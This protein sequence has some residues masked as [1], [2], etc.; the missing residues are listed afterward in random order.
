MNIDS[1]RWNL[2]VNHIAAAHW[3]GTDRRRRLLRRAGLRLAPDA[4]VQYGT[5]FFGA[6]VEIGPGSF[7]NHG[8]YFD[9]RGP[10]R[11]G[12]RC[13]VSMQ[14]M[15]CTSTH[16]P[17]DRARRAGRYDAAPIVIGDGVWIGVRAMVL[18]GVTIGDGCVI[19]AG[20]IVREDCEPHGLYAGVP[21]R[22]VRELPA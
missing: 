9:S 15:L 13:D 1:P 22:R 6:D 2:L 7:V 18:P 14:V 8:C 3:I 19:A 4:C 20:A 16:E 11:I 21:A 17:G 5:Y 12:A 10:I